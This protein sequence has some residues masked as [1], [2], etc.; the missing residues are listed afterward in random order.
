MK[1]NF[2]IKIA[3]QISAIMSKKGMSITDV[4]NEIGVSVSFLAKFL[5]H[6]NKISAER[7]HQILDALDHDLVFEEKKTLLNLS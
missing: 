2:Y 7:L 5:N 6:G 1:E 4:A 3:R